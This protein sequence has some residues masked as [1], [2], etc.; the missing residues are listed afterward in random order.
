MSTE[1]TP[2]PRPYWHMDAK[3]IV[4]L[5][6][7]FVLALTLLVS[8]LVQVTGEKPAV[9]TLSMVMALVLSEG[10][11]DDESDAAEMREQLRASSEGSIQPIPGLRITISEEEIANLSPRQVRLAFM[12]KLA[13]PIY[14]GG[15]QEL[16]ALA[17]D[18]K[19]QQDIIEGRGR[20]A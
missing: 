3:W 8:S 11:L 12:R 7:V 4:G 1:H 20:S 13:E 16:A 2:K 10:G 5:I 19:M 15:A 6:L 9:D 14:E 18:A 17:D